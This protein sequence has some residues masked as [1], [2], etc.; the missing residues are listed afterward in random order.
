MSQDGLLTADEEGGLVKAL[1]SLAA[2]ADEMG[3]LGKPLS[4]WGREEM[5]CFCTRAVR[6]AVPLRKHVYFDPGLDDRIPFGA[7]A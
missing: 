1:P 4:E 6:A 7:D 2:L 5:L 3:V